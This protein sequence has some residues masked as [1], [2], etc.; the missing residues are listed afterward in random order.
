MEEVS[1]LGL[2]ALMALGLALIGIARGTIPQPGRKAVRV[3][4]ALG[5]L[6]AG[7]AGSGPESLFA[8]ALVGGAV[9]ADWFAGPPGAEGRLRRF[10]LALGLAA[11]SACLAIG[12]T[13]VGPRHPPLTEEGYT[14]VT[15]GMSRVQV[16]EVLGPPR[17]ECGGA[18]VS[19]YGWEYRKRG[20]DSWLGPVEELLVQFDGS[21][22]AVDVRRAPVYWVGSRSRAQRLL[23]WL[24]Q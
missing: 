6:T 22:T 10:G 8:A 9:A 21:G 24:G 17:D 12:V 15:A 11:A 1:G 13:S 4:V 7:L 3:A 14:R 23:A 19:H 2:F 18:V 5:A 16:E 20:Y